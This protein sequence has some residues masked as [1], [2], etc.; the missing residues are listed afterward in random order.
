MHTLGVHGG[1]AQSDVT[2]LANVLNGWT[3]ARESTLPQLDA[4]LALTYNAGN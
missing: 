2:A 4:P 1:Y 3:L